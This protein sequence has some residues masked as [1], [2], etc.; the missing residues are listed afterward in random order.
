MWANQ[1]EGFPFIGAGFKRVRTRERSW[2]AIVCSGTM[3]LLILLVGED[4]VHSLGYVGKGEVR[5]YKRYGEGGCELANHVLGEG[6]EENGECFHV[7]DVG[8]LQF[9]M[10]LEGCK[11]KMELL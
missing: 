3:W 5:L 1:K 9:F 4:D 6:I 10:L 11:G 2:R 7:S 8:F